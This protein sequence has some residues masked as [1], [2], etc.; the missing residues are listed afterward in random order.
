M[1]KL[2]PRNRRERRGRG[3]EQG[4]GRRAQER[5]PCAVSGVLG[6]VLVG[7][8]VQCFGLCLCSAVWVWVVSGCGFAVGL[9]IWVSRK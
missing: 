9:C 7:A 8:V 3:G 1:E 6:S 4:R 5:S 2:K